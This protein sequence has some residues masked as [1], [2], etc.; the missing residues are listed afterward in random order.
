VSRRRLALA[1]S[2]VASFV[3]SL[4]AAPAA[5]AQGVSGQCAA[6][7]SIT[8]DACQKA[9]D[10]FNFMAPQL[11][12]SI[13]GGNAVIGHVTTLGGL[14][15]FT[16]GLR[17]N[18]I[19]GQLPQTNNVAVSINGPQSSNFAPKSQ[20]LGLPTGEAAIGVFQGIGVGLTNVG[21]VDALVSAYY[22]PDIDKDPVRVHPTVSRLKLGYGL[23]VGV[24]QETSI[25]PGVSLSYLRR[26]L[27]KLDLRARIGS[28][29]SLKVTGLTEKTSEWRLAASKRFAIVSI[30]GG[31]GQDRYS[32]STDIGAYIAP[33]TVAPG[34]TASF[35]GTVASASQKLTRTNMFVGTSVR[36]SPVRVAAEVGRV[37]GGSVAAA[38]NSFGG[39]KAD[40]P[41]TYASIG[42]RIGY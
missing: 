32:S 15:H 3:T 12:T 6:Q 17:A 7:T 39:K 42:L 13:V 36:L 23:R 4:A 10:L 2:A 14:G 26:D 33:R 19:R 22:V 29:D 35:N 5:R 31:L 21:G 28:G 27:P 16:L 37:S 11:G 24:L 38:Y 25:V 20:V 18:V 8:R 41:Y 40:D 30:Q 34:V 1:A 9:I